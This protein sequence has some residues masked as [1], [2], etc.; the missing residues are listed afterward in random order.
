[1]SYTFP[2]WQ[3]LHS[4]LVFCIVLFII[5]FLYTL[6]SIEKDYLAL[7]CLDEG[8]GRGVGRLNL[9]QELILR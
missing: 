5:L 3:N 1:M 6:Y 2:F 4:V 7:C 9:T 8:R